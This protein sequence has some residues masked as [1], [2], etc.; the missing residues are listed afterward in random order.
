MSVESS[1]A[2]APWPHLTVNYQFFLA[3]RVS[4]MSILNWNG[5]DDGE[6]SIDGNNLAGEQ[7]RVRSGRQDT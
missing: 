5:L 7:N 1:A 3:N 2:V 4:G 6:L